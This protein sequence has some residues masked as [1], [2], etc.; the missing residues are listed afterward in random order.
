MATHVYLYILQDPIVTLYIYIYIY[1]IQQNTLFILMALIM[2][3]LQWYHSQLWVKH[4]GRTISQWQWQSV[5]RSLLYRGSFSILLTRKVVCTP[6]WCTLQYTVYMSICIRQYIAAQPTVYILTCI[7]A[8]CIK[9]V[10]S[11]HCMRWYLYLYAH[12]QRHTYRRTYCSVPGSVV[13]MGIW[14]RH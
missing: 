10:S 11:M 13:K 3:M 4:L 6:Q 5:C 7:A 9:I 12:I 14:N 8:R 1:K 2:S